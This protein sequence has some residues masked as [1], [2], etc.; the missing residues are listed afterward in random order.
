MC[1]SNCFE[2]M[3]LLTFALLSGFVDGVSLEA[4]ADVT[5]A[6]SSVATLVT[7]RGTF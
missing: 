3:N 2:A 7:A 1:S 6:G 5:F 4:A